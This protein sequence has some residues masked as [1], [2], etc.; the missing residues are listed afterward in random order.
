MQRTNVQRTS[1]LTAAILACAGAGLTTTAHAQV[2]HLWKFGPTPVNNEIASTGG[3]PATIDFFDGPGGYT[4]TETKFGTN[5]S[6]G[7]PAIEGQSTVGVMN[8]PYLPTQNETYRVNHKIGPNGPA[9]SLYVNQYTI[10]FDLLLPAE[11]FN[12]PLSGWFS[13]FNTN[14]C[15]ANDGDLY[16]RMPDGGIGIIG[17]YSTAP[18]ILPDTWHRVALVWDLCA[19]PA[20]VLRKY[21]DGVQTEAQSLNSGCEGRWALYANT[22]PQYPWFFIFG[23]NDGETNPAF[24]SAFAVTDRALTDG[25]VQALGGVKAA[26]I[27]FADA[28]S[29]YPDCDASGSLSIDDFICFQTFFALGDPSA[30]CDASGSLSIDDFIC[31]Q[32]FFALGC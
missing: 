4:A 8:V 31:F 3:T 23:D 19:S 21:I 27:E 1:V 6:F 10:V 26:G 17:E 32:T 24:A 15:N 29:C 2:E 28:P 25:E 16:V 12:N 7:L 11:A 9:G 22:D 13:F 18:V 20:P 14:C 5:G 30:D